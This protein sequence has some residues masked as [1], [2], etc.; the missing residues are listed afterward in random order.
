MG[1]TRINS[2]LI[3]DGE[4][5]SSDLRVGACTGNRIKV[6]DGNKGDTIASDASSNTITIPV[7]ADGDVLTADSGETAGLKWAAP[8]ADPYV[9]HPHVHR[10]CEHG[11]GDGFQRRSG[12]DPGERAQSGE[13]PASTLRRSVHRGRG[14]D[15][16]VQ[17]LP[18]ISRDLRDK[19]HPHREHRDISRLA[20]GSRNDRRD[21]RVVRHAL[22]Q[23][24]DRGE[25]YRTV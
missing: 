18:R 22:V 17:G 13:R 7:G 10:S 24:H 1:N 8:R 5:N 14:T 11:D 21:G 19:R 20:G 2:R 9:V 3:G 25:R 6:G 15:V 16:A 4:V 12:L 23:R